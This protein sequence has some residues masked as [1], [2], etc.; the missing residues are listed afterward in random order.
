MK[1]LTL[2]Q[3]TCCF[4]LFTAVS[5][6]AAPMDFRELSLLVRA[7]ESESSIIA[8]ASQRKL[9]RPLTPQQEATLKSQGASDS[10]IR[11]LRDSKTVLSQTDAAAYEAERSAATARRSPAEPSRTGAGPN[12]DILD[13]ATDHP[14]NLSYWGGP[15]YDFAFRARDIVETGRS[16]VQLIQPTG[17]ATSYA[18][19]HG[20]RVPGWESIDPH[21][22]AIVDRVYARPLW[23]DWQHPTRLEGVPY[24]LYPVYA[25]G[26][27]ALYYI[28]H[29]TDESVK[30]ALVSRR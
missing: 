29:S 18:T 28:G 5:S 3:I 6:L 21:Y 10:L 12:I 8:D 19:Y 20:E 4:I 14:I 22:T 9:V 11:S 26:G 24:I 2:P 17:T 23:I 1:N 13:V 27:V 16:E 25:A 30:L 7:H 15:D